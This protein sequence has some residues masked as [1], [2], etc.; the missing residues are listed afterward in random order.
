[1][2]AIFR[3]IAIVGA[4]QGDGLICGIAQVR[5]FADAKQTRLIQDG[6]VAL[7]ITDASGRRVDVLLTPEEAMQLGPQVC[8]AAVIAAAAPP[9]MLATGDAAP[10]RIVQ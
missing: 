1:V 7:V 2:K 5:K 4:A 9:P 6:S 10:P 8:A 3:T